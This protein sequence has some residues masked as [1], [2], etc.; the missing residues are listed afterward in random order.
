MTLSAGLRNVD[1]T[2]DCK[3]CSHPITKSGAWVIAIS[4]FKCDKCGGELHLGYSDKVA[5]FAKFAH[6]SS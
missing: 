4:S 6:L 5:L 1:I 2:F 3:L